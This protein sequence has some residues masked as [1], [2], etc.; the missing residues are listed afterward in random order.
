MVARKH[1][2]DK[3]YETPSEWSSMGERFWVG[4]QEIKRTVQSLKAIGIM[5]SEY[6]TVIWFHDKGGIYWEPT[7]YRRLRFRYN[8][9]RD[10]W[11]PIYPK[12]EE[13]P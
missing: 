1:F 12:K 6:D 5:A 10:S 2:P 8:P 9:V 4:P 11:Y 13:Q 7:T 3:L